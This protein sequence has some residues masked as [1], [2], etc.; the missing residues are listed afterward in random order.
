MMLLLQLPALPTNAP[1]SGPEALVYWG[2][3][4]FFLILIALRYFFPSGKQR[5]EVRQ[6]N[7]INA[8]NFL[9]DQ[10]TSLK[11]EITGLK[12]E[13][14]RMSLNEESSKDYRHVLANRSQVFLASYEVAHGLLVEIKTDVAGMPDHFVKRIERL[15][16]PSA[17]ESAIPLPQTKYWSLEEVELMERLHRSSGVDVT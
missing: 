2:L 9:Q 17:L 3:F 14:R 1:T 12:L 5:L 15:R 6:A 10:I 11:G 8:I 13:V 7:E 4:A 16:Q